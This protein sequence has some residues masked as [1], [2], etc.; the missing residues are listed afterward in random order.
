MKK[1]ALVLLLVMLFTPSTSYA[2]DILIKGGTEILLK[3]LDKLKSG[4]VK[5]GQIIRF[6]VEKEVRDENDFVLIRDGAN[7]YGTVLKSKKAGMFGTGG[8]LEISINQVE[9]FNRKDVPL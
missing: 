4:E 3:V 7:A 2:D 1:M 5:S 8:E 6:L 9:A